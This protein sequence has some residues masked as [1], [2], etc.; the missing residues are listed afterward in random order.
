MNPFRTNPSG[1][2]KLSVPYRSPD[3][4]HCS[5]GCQWSSIGTCLLFNRPIIQRHKDHRNLR[6]KE[7]LRYDSRRGRPFVVCLCGSTRFY[8]AFQQA[9]FDESM[10]GGIVLSVG[11]A[12]GIADGEHN[13]KAG[14]I[15]PFRKQ[16]L[17]RL[18]FSKIDMS[19]EILVL[20]VGGYVG[21]S[22]AREIEHARSRGKAIRWL[23][24]NER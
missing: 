15:T 5:A 13:E 19:D 7:C 14:G 4:E 21:E 2:G 12:P 10:K 1:R 16:M 17:D 3:G 6:C 24:P 20:N 9:Y 22:T 23:E 8:K 11:F 18:H